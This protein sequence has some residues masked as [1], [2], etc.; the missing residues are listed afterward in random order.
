MADVNISESPQAARSHVICNIVLRGGTEKWQMY[1]CVSSC[2][3]VTCHMRPCSTRRLSIMTDV[4]ISEPPHV[5]GS[6]V[7]CN[8]DPREGSE[9]RQM[10]IFL[11]LLMQPGHM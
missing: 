8:L 11:S 2:N 10:H 6:H 3:Q 5:T 1:F 4:N 9:K 7:I